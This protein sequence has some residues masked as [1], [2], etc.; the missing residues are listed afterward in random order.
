MQ[1]LRT[2]KSK[3]GQ[4]LNVQKN[5]GA[6]ATHPH[7]VTI[8]EIRDPANNTREFDPNQRVW[9]RAFVASHNGVTQEKQPPK[10]VAVNH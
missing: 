9:V 2:A 4:T 5:R 7:E 3:K 6:K 1:S 10:L 8:A